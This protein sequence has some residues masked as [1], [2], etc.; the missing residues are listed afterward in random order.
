MTSLRWRWGLVLAVLATQFG[1]AADLP[2]AGRPSAPDDK[3]KK[4]ARI[5]VSKQTT[6]LR[7]MRRS[8]MHGQRRPCC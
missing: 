7:F 4:G 6:S 2:T 8:G 5:S 3:V 1:L